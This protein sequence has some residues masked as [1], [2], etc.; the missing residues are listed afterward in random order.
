MKLRPLSGGCDLG[1]DPFICYW[2]RIFS[3]NKRITI[4]WVSLGEKEEKKM[5]LF[6]CSSILHEVLAFAPQE[7]EDLAT[8]N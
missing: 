2:P 6:L 5:N 4:S 1:K 8:G 3:Q 7:R